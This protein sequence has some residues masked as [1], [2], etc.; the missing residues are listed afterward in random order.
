[1]QQRKIPTIVG[2]LLV[3][4]AVMIFRYAF[5]RVTPLLTRASVS[6]APKNMTVTNITDTS[7]TVTWITDKPVSGSVKLDGAGMF[8]DERY[9]DA[10]TKAQTASAEYTTHSVPVR[11][12]KPDTAY[13]FTILSNGAPA[14]SGG[15]PYE[16]KTA[17]M[18]TGLGTG[19]EPAYGQ[20][21]AQNGLPLESAI[22]YLTLENGQTLSTLS[23][24]TGTWVIPLNLVRSS[25]L[26]RFVQNA[27]RI[28]ETLVIRAGDG[29]STALTDTL[30]DNPVPAMTIGKTY[31]FRKIQA[32]NIP[33]QQPLAQASPSPAVLGT[34]TDKTK[35]TVSITKPVD[36]SAIP[37]N[38]PLIQGT[39]I[40]G[41]QILITIGI[42]KP[43]SDT[44]IVG[45]DGIWRYTPIKPLSEGK[46]SVTITT[47]NAQSKTVAIT[48]TFEVLKSGTQVLGDATPSA[49]LTPLPTV[50]NEPTPTSTLAGEPI[51]ETGFPLPLITLIILGLGMVSSGLVVLRK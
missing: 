50:T 11:N 31:D 10:T 19:I 26:T 48:H 23:K 46:Q 3:V 42:E 40:T 33:P 21:S 39:G 15:K 24:A 4:A 45:G 47:T 43:M 51:P 16:T 2:L 37:S 38:L 44:V 49:T 1:M 29:E 17:P 14:N 20:I 6:H 5:D 12:L 27:E 22:V 36:G 35:Q 9:A 13:K 41:N 25:D 28:D 34:N 18:I 7:F 30:N 32:E 8:F